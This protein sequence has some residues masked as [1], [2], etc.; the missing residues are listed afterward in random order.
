MTITIDKI[1]LKKE[2]LTK[3]FKDLT[4]KL[5]QLEADKIATTNNALAING[6]IQACE[7]LIE[8][9]KES[10]NDGTENES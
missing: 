10:E 4:D 5:K 2:Q 8:E 9:N 7:Q 6:A 1:E 3:D